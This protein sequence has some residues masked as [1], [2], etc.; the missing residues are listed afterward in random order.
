MIAFFYGFRE[1]FDTFMHST[2]EEVK[3]L[4]PIE[5]ETWVGL[6]TQRLVRI[7]YT[8]TKDWARAEDCVQDAYIKAFNKWHQFDKD[9]GEVFPWL[10]AIVIN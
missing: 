2:G 3:S 4:L 7:A 5:L 1:P 10:V 6:Y 9:R 8:Y